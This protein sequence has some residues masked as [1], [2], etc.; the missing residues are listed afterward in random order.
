MFDLRINKKYM[1]ITLGLCLIFLAGFFFIFSGKKPENE[2]RLNFTDAVEEI[3]RAYKELKLSDLDTAGEETVSKIKK[4]NDAMVAFVDAFGSRPPTALERTRDWVKKITE[5]GKDTKKTEELL[6][7]GNCTDARAEVE[8]AYGIFRQIKR[9]NFIGDKTDTLFA[10]YQAGIA[11]ANASSKEAAVDQ[12]PSLKLI[13]TDIKEKN[14][15]KRYVSLMAQ[16]E[17]AIGDIEKLLPGP[18][19]LRAQS[20]LKTLVHTIYLDY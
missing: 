20:D 17:K 3:D 18:D 14:N 7:E 13:F 16:T 9:E 12:L 6:G 11:V 8:K 4:L 15:D 5:I 10:F 2:S 1:I 19:F